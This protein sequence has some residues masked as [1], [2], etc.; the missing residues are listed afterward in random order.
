M[1]FANLGL[2]YMVKTVALGSENAAIGWWPR[3]AF[4]SP[5]SLLSGTA[6][7]LICSLWA[8]CQKLTHQEFQ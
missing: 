1:L 2:V 3:A 5:R 4:P 8:T 7:S 6:S